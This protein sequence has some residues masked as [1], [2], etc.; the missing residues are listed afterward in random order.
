MFRGMIVS[1]SLMGAFASAQ[2]LTEISP[3]SQAMM[4]HTATLLTSGRVLLVGTSGHSEVFDPTTSVWSASVSMN[5][6][7]EG[8][9]ATRLVDGR[10]LVVGGYVLSLPDPSTGSRSI[11]GTVARGETFDPVSGTWSAAGSLSTSR[12]FHTATPLG[13]GDVLVVGGATFASTA[14]N[15]IGTIERYDGNTGTWTVVGALPDARRGHTATLLGNGD[16]LVL[17]G[18]DASNAKTV[19]CWRLNPTSLITTACAPLPNARSGHTATALSDGRVFVAGGSD[20]ASLFEQIFNPATNSWVGTSLPSRSSTNHASF[21]YTGDSIVVWGGGAA[22]GYSPGPDVPPTIGPASRNYV[23]TS[24]WR[25]LLRLPGLAGH[26]VTTLQDGR[27]LVAGGFSSYSKNTSLGIFYHAAPSAKSYLLDRMQAS[28]FSFSVDG[29]LPV[30]PPV[31]SRY[32]VRFAV[33]PMWYDDPIPTGTVLVSDGS[34]SCQATLPA[35][36]CRLTAVSGG[37]KQYTISYSGDAEYFPDSLL[38]KR[39]ANANVRVER[40]GSGGGVVRLQNNV[41]SG[42]KYCAIGSPV[43]AYDCDVSFAAGTVITATATAAVG[44]VFVGWQS[45]C[46]GSAATCTFTVQGAGETVVTAVFA[47]SSAA[48]LTLD[49]DSNSNLSATSDGLLLQRYLSKLHDGALTTGALGPFALRA[50]GNLIEDRIGDLLPLLDV[51]Q[52]GVVDPATDGVI[53]LRYLIGVRGDALVINALAANA[54]RTDAAAIQAA[55][56]SMAPP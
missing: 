20:S 41:N 3:M 6:G 8:H 43:Y 47:V 36:E 51:D 7:S 50:D 21:A 45:A 31:R 24:S 53:I 46:G 29:T 55:L 30:L 27:V 18:S 49:L 54:R 2:S 22:G 9:T 34:A 39:P 13:N 4:G 23:A 10:V 17:G 15:S 37:E 35:S 1:F 42:S 16:L 44:S 56:A 19:S 5:Q 33:G 11:T 25:Q 26:S 48:P 32:K 28:L 12:A 14:L 38:V 52:N 40:Q